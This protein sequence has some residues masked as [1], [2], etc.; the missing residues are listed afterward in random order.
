MQQNNCHCGNQQAALNDQDRMEDLLS[1]EKYLINAYGTFIPEATCPQLRL[2]LTANFNDCVQNQY[3]VFDQMNQM[4]W[5]PT[6]PAP[7]PEIDAARQKFAQLK[8]QL[9]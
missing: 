4:G 1:Q 5:Y 8:Q 3:T 2:V 9:G 7:M 6:K